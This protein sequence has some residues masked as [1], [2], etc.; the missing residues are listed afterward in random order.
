MTR[1]DL[2]FTNKIKLSSEDEDSII[3]E[4]VAVTGN[5]NSKYLQFTET[6][7]KQ[8]AKS[9]KDVK[10]LIDHAYDSTMVVGKV[11][12]TK[13]K[14]EIV[15]FEGD[16]NPKH[17]SQIHISLVRGDVD[18]ASVGGY[19]KSIKCS[20]CNSEA[21]ECEHFI[22]EKY[23]G[24]IAVGLVQDFSAQELSLT[25]FPADKNAKIDNVYAVAQTINDA[26]KQRGII[27]IRHDEDEESAE[28]FKRDANRSDDELK[29]KIQ[30]GIDMETPTIDKTPEVKQTEAEAQLKVLQSMVEKLAQENE[31]KDKE[32]TNLSQRLDKQEDF[33]S[34]QIA[35]ERDEKIQEIVRLSGIELAEIEKLEDS[36]LDAQLQVVRKFKKVN[37]STASVRQPNVEMTKTQRKELVRK[38]FGFPKPSEKAVKIIQDMKDEKEMMTNYSIEFFSRKG[39]E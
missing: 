31:D 18:A 36:L 14:E 7:L 10:I 39:D 28:S 25:A 35:K 27:D 38:V 4:G 19:A 34:K 6:A 8:A 23:K 33:I 5:V 1:Y 15:F 20:I 37:Q 17:P 2:N 9:L 24:K 22:G 12:A 26:K 11:L 21:H 3:I 16:I 30:E 13:R 32:N 29:N